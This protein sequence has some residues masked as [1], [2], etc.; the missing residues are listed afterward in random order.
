MVQT[1][2]LDQSFERIK[3]GKKSNSL[4]FDDKLIEMA[5]IRESTRAVIS[6]YEKLLPSIDKISLNAYGEKSLGKSIL[7]DKINR[8]GYTKEELLLKI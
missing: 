7:V 2:D 4:K 8:L 5:A 6:E 1:I 3:L